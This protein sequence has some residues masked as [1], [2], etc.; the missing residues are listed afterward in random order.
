VNPF[1][2]LITPITPV[3]PAGGQ[4]GAALGEAG[5][6]AA[7]Q[8]ERDRQFQQKQLD[9]Y[10]KWL[11]QAADREVKSKHF[12]QINAYYN[13]Q[14]ALHKDQLAEK[15]NALGEKRAQQLFDAF[16]KAKTPQDRENIRQELQRAGFT[17]TEAD[18]ELPEEPAAAP[19]EAAPAPAAA[20][21]TYAHPPKPGG[22]LPPI[23]KATKGVLQNH[24]EPNTV[25]MGRG[26][27][28]LPVQKTQPMG[29]DAFMASPEA[30]ASAASPEAAS[31]G[32]ELPPEMQKNPYDGGSLFPWDLA[33]FPEPKPPTPEKPK[34]GGK[35]TVTDK[36][37]NQVLQYDEPL[38][39]QKMRQDILRVG[40]PLITQGRNEIN[41]DAANRAADAA[42]ADYAA[43]G[44]S[45]KAIDLFTKLYGQQVGQFKKEF[46][47]GGGGGPAGPSKTD[48][49][50]AERDDT[51]VQHVIGRV[52][53][54]Y[55]MK[56]V[57]QSITMAKN[58]L[59]SMNEH[60]GMGDLNAF[61]QYLLAMSGKVVTDKEMEQF[62]HSSGAWTG[63]EKKYNEY[64]N[65]G[66][67]PPQF[68]RSLQ[69]LMQ[70]FI[71]NAEAKRKELG[72]NAYQQVLGLQGSEQAAAVARG[73]FTGFD[74]P[75][76]ATP[77]GQP[78][79]KAGAGHP[80]PATGGASG[81]ARAEAWLK[82]Q[83]GG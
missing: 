9:D 17:V 31:A 47:G 51:L 75:V 2:G 56:A 50:L 29:I 41:R 5:D 4:M 26:G 45:G 27:I 13:A 18:T 11:D 7:L 60:T 42:A 77:L 35:F 69:T 14:T 62:M 72:E 57:D 79:P 65:E 20:P 80:A 23:S 73:H 70:G 52:G 19:A 37:G 6:A 16:R 74:Q 55:E 1:A 28:T 43:F 78:K 76:G 21:G 12:D 49:K 22:A 63:W 54:Q 53:G 66:K 24:A 58:S 38:Q 48:I 32:G 44:D 61:K 3:A 39:Q 83:G 67:F 46:P 40:E 36:S 34:R 25:G 82:S 68:L 71:A 33:G 30:Q 59:S 10:Q 64:M 81:K 15:Q 8:R